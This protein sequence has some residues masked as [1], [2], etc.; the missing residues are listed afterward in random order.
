MHTLVKTFY[1]LSLIA[2]HHKV[3]LLFA[4][5]DYEQRNT[6]ATSSEVANRL[7]AIR[8]ELGQ[9]AEPLRF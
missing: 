5:C 6:S 9:H 4:V 3:D 8:L 7:L 2:C 1:V